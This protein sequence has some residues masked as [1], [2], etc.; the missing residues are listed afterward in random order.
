M[1]GD[2]VSRNSS[3]VGSNAYSEEAL[4]FSSKASQNIHLV[5]KQGL[6]GIKCDLQNVEGVEGYEIIPQLAAYNAKSADKAGE[7]MRD[8]Q[9]L[10]KVII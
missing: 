8:P 2:Y 5:T 1:V 6:D 4:Q 3:L 7:S 9:T 10:V